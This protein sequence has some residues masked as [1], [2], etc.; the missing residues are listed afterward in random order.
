MGVRE[1][2]SYVA[3]KSGSETLVERTE[4][5]ELPKPAATP[6]AGEVMSAPAPEPIGADDEAGAGKR[7]RS[8]SAS[9]PQ[10]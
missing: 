10:E 4:P 1:G 3:G 6:E 5:A 8:G 2:G 9:N 7:R